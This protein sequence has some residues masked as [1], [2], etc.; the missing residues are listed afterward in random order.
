MILVSQNIAVHIV[1]TLYIV[2]VYILFYNRS[3]LLIQFYWV[4]LQEYS[5]FTLRK[6]KIWYGPYAKLQVKYTYT[7]MLVRHEKTAFFSFVFFPVFS[8]VIAVVE[9]NKNTGNINKSL[10]DFYFCVEKKWRALF[11]LLRSL[12]LYLMLLLFCFFLYI[13]FAL[14]IYSVLFFAMVH[15]F[16]HV[17]PLLLRALFFQRLFLSLSFQPF[18][19][20]MHTREH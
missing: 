4:F 5:I 14:F 11:F 18:E 12:F 19:I 15:R 10:V 6:H 2:Q 9:N 17:F 20:Y 13:V 1:C 3:V 7:N 8:S 16:K